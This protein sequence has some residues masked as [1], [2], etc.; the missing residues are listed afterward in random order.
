MKIVLKVII[1]FFISVFSNLLLLTLI[2][3]MFFNNFRLLYFSL[4][5]QGYAVFL[6]VT[7]LNKGFSLSEKQAEERRR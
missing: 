1:Q 2:S 3:N 7:S 4:F 5:K 6:V